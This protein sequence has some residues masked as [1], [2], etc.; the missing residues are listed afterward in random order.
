MESVKVA[1]GDMANEA[2]RGA[3]ELVDVLA[4]VNRTR[5]HAAVDR[6]SWREPRRRWRVHGKRK[7]PLLWLLRLRRRLRDTRSRR[8]LVDAVVATPG[9]FRAWLSRRR[10]GGMDLDG[11]EG[12]PETSPTWRSSCSGAV[13]CRI[14]SSGLCIDG[15]RGRRRRGGRRPPWLQR[16][17]KKERRD[18]VSRCLQ[19]R[20]RAGRHGLSRST[21]RPM[22]YVGMRGWQTHPG[23]ATSVHFIGLSVCNPPTPASQSYNVQPSSRPTPQASSSA[24]AYDSS[25]M[26]PRGTSATIAQPHSASVRS[27]QQLADYDPRAQDPYNTNGQRPPRAAPPSTP[28]AGRQQ[29]D[30]TSPDYV[31][32]VLPPSSAPPRSNTFPAQQTRRPTETNPVHP[33]SHSRAASEPH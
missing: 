24:P 22:K 13:A 32:S 5:R 16:V 28:S 9:G 30:V 11:C 19:R 33:P 6:E 29:Y 31:Q 14:A 20:A 7:R 3:N 10:D 12:L 26:S 17:G 27:H 8:G 18:E 4:E 2:A 15:T 1:R 21:K 25:F 23:S